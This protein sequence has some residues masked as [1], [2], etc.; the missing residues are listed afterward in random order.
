[1]YAN[2]K[3]DVHAP[4]PISYPVEEG[5]AHTI[6]TRPQEAHYDA[7]SKYGMTDSMNFPS[8]GT[9]TNKT[10]SQDNSQEN[11]KDTDASYSRR[12]LAVKAAYQK[13]LDDIKQGIKAFLPS[14]GRKILVEN[15]YMK[16]DNKSWDVERSA[17]KR[18]ILEQYK[19]NPDEDRNKELVKAG[20]KIKTKHKKS[21]SKHAT[22]NIQSEK[23]LPNLPEGWTAYETIDPTDPSGR[24][25]TAYQDSS[26]RTQWNHPGIGSPTTQA[27]S[28]QTDYT[29]PTNP[30]SD[31]YSGYTP[32]ESSEMG[33]F[34][35]AIATEPTTGA[36]PIVYPSS[37]GI[38]TAHTGSYF[39]SPH[40]KTTYP[41]DIEV[42]SRQLSSKEPHNLTFTNQM[43]NSLTREDLLTREDRRN[44][45]DSIVDK[46]MRR[47][48]I[49]RANQEGN[50]YPDKDMSEIYFQVAKELGLNSAS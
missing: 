46:Y 32:S 9:S 33:G 50:L 19:N 26:G 3:N 10:Y 34:S 40:T 24:S 27:S 23:A 48:F 1:M 20:F 47:K 11:Y 41:E 37:V 42:D 6:D 12:E 13:Y 2:P 25:H 39:S 30:R 15:G 21:K 43:P 17:F 31:I 7:S 22:P 38:Y 14:S 4:P 8:Q 28:V 44:F 49:E 16:K 35:T 29:V 36:S 45:R 18:S 5:V